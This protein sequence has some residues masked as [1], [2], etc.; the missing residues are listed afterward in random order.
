MIDCVVTHQELYSQYFLKV[1]VN[2][3]LKSWKKKKNV[4]TIY[5]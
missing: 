4:P 1:N 5:S 3:V 2:N